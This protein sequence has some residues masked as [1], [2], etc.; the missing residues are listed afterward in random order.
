MY[1]KNLISIIG[2]MTVLK[3]GFWLTKVIGQMF[4]EVLV[5]AMKQLTLQSRTVLCAQ[6]VSE[7]MFE[8]L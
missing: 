6:T 4:C 2:L 8:G 1:I 7:S 3:L 5:T